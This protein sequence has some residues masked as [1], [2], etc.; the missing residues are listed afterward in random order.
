M[1]ALHA[2]LDSWL[3]EPL[4]LKVEINTRGHF[5]RIRAFWRL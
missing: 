4:K 5:L 2:R 1:T 3:G